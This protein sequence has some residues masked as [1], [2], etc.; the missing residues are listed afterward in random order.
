M[1][2]ATT[3]LSVPSGGA[4]EPPAAPPTPPKVFI[5]A[6]DKTVHGVLIQSWSG[7][8]NLAE[9]SVSDSECATI[10]TP[11]G[12][13]PTVMA[14]G[15]SENDAASAAGIGIGFSAFHPDCLI[16]WYSC[17]ARLKHSGSSLRYIIST[18][19]GR[20]TLPRREI[21]VWNAAPSMILGET[22]FWSLS[23]SASAFA[24]RSFCASNWRRNSPLS[25]F[26]IALTLFE[27]MSA[28][29]AQV[30]AKRPSTPAILSINDFHD[31]KVILD[32]LD[33]ILEEGLWFSVAML[34]LMSRLVFYRT[35]LKVNSLHAS[36]R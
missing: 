34:F 36:N 27:R 18:R 17:C 10:V 5:T 12:W 24:V 19:L 8:I 13:P 4:Y 22:R 32:R 29:T 21:Y 25:F 26:C 1:R 30:A 7:K 14:V 3:T 16:N 33:E 31:S 28:I 35:C 9:A 11:E 20:G 2:G 15:R 23:T 6:L